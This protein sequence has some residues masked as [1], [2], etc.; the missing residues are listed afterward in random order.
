MVSRPQDTSGSPRSRLIAAACLGINFL[1]FGLAGSTPASA[2][3]E[4]KITICHAV[5]SITNPYSE[6]TVNA[7]SIVNGN[8]HG[9][10]AGPVFPAVD[11]D[12]NWGDIIPPF[13]HSGGTFPGVNWTS[14]GQAILNGGCEV[15]LTP[16]LP[17]PEP[18]TTTTTHPPTATTHPPTATTHPP[19]ATTHP[20]TATTHPPTATTHPPTATTHPPTATTHPPPTQPGATTTTSGPSSTTVPPHVST[21]PTTAPPSE[22]PPPVVDPPNGVEITGPVE[23]VVIDPSDVT[24]DLG[25]LSVPERVALEAQLDPL[26]ATGTNLVPIGIT[27]LLIILLGGALI[28]IPGRRRRSDP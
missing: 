2:A 3:P 20:P 12:G 17:G 16:I 10:H 28:A 7:N 6:Q 13:R 21:P 5:S 1:A 18:T 27:G 4:D 9:D 11:S 23:A 14:D 25:E 15:D 22:R 26:A 8:G 19:T 24:Y